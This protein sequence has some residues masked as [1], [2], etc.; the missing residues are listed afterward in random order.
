MIFFISVIVTFGIIFLRAFQ[1]KNVANNQYLLIGVTGFLIA[2]LEV[3]GIQ[4][5]LTGGFAIAL[6]AGIGAAIGATSAVWLHNRLF[7]RN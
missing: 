5:A 3:S 4:I 7:K 6:T 2:A 1:Q